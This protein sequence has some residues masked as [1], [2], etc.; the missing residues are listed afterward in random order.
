MHYIMKVHE[1]HGSIFFFIGRMHRKKEK[2]VDI[3]HRTEL[4]DHH[5]DG[6]QDNEAEKTPKFLEFLL[7][8]ETAHLQLGILAFLIGFRVLNALVCTTAFVPDEYW[9]SLEVAH[10]MAF[11]YPP[12]PM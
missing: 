6:S 4:S 5:V 1:R 10:R 7:K 11:G 3:S 2:Q 9:Q 12:L 8:G